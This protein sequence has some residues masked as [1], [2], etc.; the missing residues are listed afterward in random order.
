MHFDELD[1]IL[2][3]EV[4]ERHDAVFAEVLGDASYGCD[5]MDLVDCMVTPPERTSQTF[6]GTPSRAEARPAD[7]LLPNMRAQRIVSAVLRSFGIASICPSAISKSSTQMIE[8]PKTKSA[9][10]FICLR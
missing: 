7:D 10:S 5:V 9:Y 2:D 6:D 3:T 1:Q 4:G 8:F